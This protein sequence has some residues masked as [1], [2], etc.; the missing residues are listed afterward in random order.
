[1]SSLFLVDMTRNLT[2]RKWH[3]AP[4]HV[5]HEAEESCWLAAHLCMPGSNDEEDHSIIDT[6]RSTKENDYYY[7]VEDTYVEQALSSLCMPVLDFAFLRV[8]EDD[9]DDDDDDVP[10]T[11]L[12]YERSITTTEI[13]N[14]CYEEEEECD[15]GDGQQQ[16][17]T[18]TTTLKAKAAP[19]TRLNST[20]HR[21]SLINRKKMRF[22]KH[23]YHHAGKIQPYFARRSPGDDGVEASSSISRI[24]RAVIGCATRIQRAV[25]LYL[26][27]KKQ[28]QSDYSTTLLL[29]AD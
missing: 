6:D 20:R 13:N 21:V 8:H 4:V 3:Q 9:D 5:K 23:R 28:F 25:R 10:T 15:E 19:Q 11:Q 26:E 2:R 16:Q 22:N 27:R 14:E 7:Q 24:Q 29:T 1:M 12:D 18:T 17:T